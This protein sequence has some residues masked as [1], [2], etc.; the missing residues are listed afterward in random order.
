MVANRFES[1]RVARA[2]VALAALPGLCLAVACWPVVA[3]ESDAA[4]VDA[5]LARMTLEEQIQMLHGTPEP[6]PTNQG[7]AG[8]LPGI[9]RLGIG[10]MRFADGPPGVL[11]RFPATAL[12]ATMGLA[13]T[14][15][16]EDAR[17]NGA[18]IARDARALGIDVV[19]EPFI[20]AIRASSAP[21]TR[22]ARTRC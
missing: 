6:A 21:T 5:L 11:T 1:A 22:W 15:S 9:P 10:P 18:L 20:S 13:A 3:Q 19:L 12:T 2:R 8:Y 16:R 7:Q 4:R 17:D 14:F